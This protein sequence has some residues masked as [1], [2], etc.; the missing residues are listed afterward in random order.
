MSD[1]EKSGSFYLGR[2]FDLSAGATLD[3]KVL[4]E[5]KDLTTHAV[6]V[7]MTG[8]GKTG[9]CLSLI[10]EAGLDG[11]PV[12]AIDP[13]GD[14]GNLMLT[15]PNLEPS[16]FRPWIDERVAVQKG[17]TPDELAENTASL[18]SSGL[19]DWD[20]DGERIQRY[21]D[22]VEKVI[23]TPGSSAG[24]P[25]TVIKS[26]EA[27][28]H[29]MI[30]DSDVFSDRVQSTVS[31]LLSLLGIDADP[32]RSREH[33]LLSNVM[34]RAW[35][36]GRDLDLPSLIQEIQEPE[37]D[38]VGVVD[39]EKFYPE[40]DRQ[41]LAMQLNNL[42]ASPSFASWLQGESLSVKN[43]MHNSEGKPKLSIV[44]IAH[45]ND[46][47][48]M[49][50]VTILLNE[51]LSWMRMQP[52]TGSLRAIL[53]MD[54][55][56]GYFP[57]TANPP[58]K[59]PMLTLLKQ[60]RA[61]GLGVVLATQNPVDLDYKGLSNAGTWFL[62]RLQTERDKARVLE[63]LEGASAQA[64]AS[65]NKAAMEATLAGLGSRVFLMNSV[66]ENVPTVFHTRWAMSYLAGP[67][68][69]EQIHSLMYE[70]E[71]EPEDEPP[72]DQE[73]N[74]E[75]KESEKHMQA[76]LSSSR[77]ILSEKIPQVYWTLGL[78]LSANKR[79][80][81]RP[82]LIS[83]CKLHYVHSPSGIDLWKE[84][85]VL[86]TIS[87]RMPKR[88][89]DSIKT[90]ETPP[91]LNN[92]GEQEAHFANVPEEIADIK[93]YK[94]WQGDLE[95]RLHQS[96]RYEVWQSVSMNEYARPGE[97]LRDFRIRMT[98]VAR[99][100]R[101]KKKSVVDGKYEKRL[102]EARKAVRKAESYAYEQK[103][104][105]WT[106]IVNL[107]WRFAEWFLGASR[108]RRPSA[109][110]ARRVMRERKQHTRAEKKLEEKRMELEELEATI[111]AE[112]DRIELEFDPSSIQ[113]DKIEV[114]PRKKDIS[115]GDVKLIWL[116]WSIDMEGNTK[117]EYSF[118]SPST[119]DK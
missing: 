19:A 80:E 37:F 74:A 36:K 64:G 119:G 31:G 9:L 18:W 43:M 15:F 28:P 114:P 38:K 108:A 52:G 29:V 73:E 48:R 115:V 40:K 27:P 49:F 102:N 23:Y 96:E 77:P 79:L 93:N 117:P 13:K 5:S 57:P 54:E 32:V 21:N 75:E 88:M 113:P 10:E 62:G 3:P 4:Y 87:S 16:D 90:S 105:V 7:G 94:T 71:E 55:V 50:F 39:L 100:K 112:K 103:S 46:T 111:Q 116:P 58:S 81:Y 92:E 44:S 30:E 85:T 6:C 34:D 60:A 95:N 65:F 106:L 17:I 67:L 61:Y 2:K 25:L 109:S 47:E 26:F 66:H 98:Q 68:T 89:W 70:D 63:G 101:D 104:Q 33:I 14:L 72:E 8:S 22:H 82:G 56:F 12:I 42:L 110:S 76:T 91:P 20:Q 99:E 51:I 11:I 83:N 41:E 78:V 84:I 45:L 59:K 97:T 69:R 86:Q 53:Y 24:I 107:V 118:G 35:R 1:Y